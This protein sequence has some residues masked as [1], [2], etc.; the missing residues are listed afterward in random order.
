M[1]PA[2]A[3][4]AVVLA[5]STE[6]DALMSRWT[7][8]SHA[9]V[10]ADRRL[11]TGTVPSKAALASLHRLAA[12]EL[13]VPGR[14]QLRAAPAAPRPKTWWEQLLSWL[15]DRWKALMQALFG[16][17]HI[18]PRAAALIGDLII[19]LLVFAVAAAAIR[20]LVVYGR[21]GQRLAAV[22][23]LTPAADA[24]TLYAM[25]SERADRG[26]YTAAG[27]LLFRAMLAL[28]DV[29]G[30]VRDDASATVGEI[31][32]R[33]PARDVIAAFDSVATMFVAGT[34]AESP[35]DAAQWECAR[36]AYLSL[37]REPAA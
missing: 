10:P 5:N 21:R 26:E 6:R 2:A 13:S 14:Y 16:H 3:V 7:H 31:R 11:Q 8:A 32:R 34:Y 36:D 18:N 35:L 28:L 17:A 27:Q 37:A 9:T 22:H 25:A 20:I 23:A 24:A 19:A 29:R 1:I 30:S 12:A 33:L 15:G 4:L